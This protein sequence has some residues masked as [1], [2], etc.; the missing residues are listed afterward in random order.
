M[1]TLRCRFYCTSCTIFI[2][3]LPIRMFIFFVIE[4]TRLVQ[5]R[6]RQEGKRRSGVRGI[7]PHE[8]FIIVF[9]MNCIFLPSFIYFHYSIY[10]L[11]TP[12]CNCY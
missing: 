4:K 2:A 12:A 8:N 1:Y 11:S 5:K 6:R 10:V 9:A 3:I 7:R